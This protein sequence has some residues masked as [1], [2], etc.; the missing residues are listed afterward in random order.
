MLEKRCKERDREKEEILIEKGA[1]I[2]RLASELDAAQKRLLNGESN[3][4]KEKVLQLTTERNAAREQVKE[5]GVNN[6]IFLFGV[7]AQHQLYT[8]R[9]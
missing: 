8:R 4:P 6:Y 5:L 7:V 3:R 9:L 2:N 1:T